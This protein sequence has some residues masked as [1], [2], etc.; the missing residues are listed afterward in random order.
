[1]H[2]LS[3]SDLGTALKAEGSQEP[4]HTPNLKKNATEE[5]N[6]GDT[7]KLLFRIR[8]L[9]A[10]IDAEM[11]PPPEEVRR[12]LSVPPFLAQAP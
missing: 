12:N 7:A 3:L 6:P 11:V 2:A 8:R 4:I 9:N 5:I 1:M 10:S